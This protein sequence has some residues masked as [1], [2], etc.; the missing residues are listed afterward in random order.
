[1]ERWTGAI[2]LTLVVG[3]LAAI[4]LVLLGLGGGGIQL[5]LA[6]PIEIQGA[7]GPQELRVVLT[8]PEGVRVEAGGESQATLRTSLEGIPCPVCG[9]GV[10]VPVKWNPF[11]GEIS[12]RCTTCGYTLEEQP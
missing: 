3:L 5:R 2:A 10:M 1:M 9:E 8:L 4:L 6:G 7:T 11:T 12:W